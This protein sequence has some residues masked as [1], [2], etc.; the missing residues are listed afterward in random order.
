MACSASTNSRI[1]AAGSDQGMLNRRWTWALI[2][3]PSP[4]RKRPELKDC[5]SLATMATVIGLRANA[6]ATAVPSVSVRDWPA[7]SK[8]GRNGSRLTSVVQTPS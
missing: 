2:W 5:R 8:S 3:E 4:R 6:T 7:A 1:R